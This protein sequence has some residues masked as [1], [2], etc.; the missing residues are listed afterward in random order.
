MEKFNVEKHWDDF[1]EGKLVVNCPTEELANEFLR[2]CHNQNKQW[3]IESLLCHNNWNTYEEQTCYCS[4]N[5]TM[6]Y[7]SIKYW[8]RNNFKI[9]E[10]QGFDIQNKTIA[11]IGDTIVLS[12]GLKMKLVMEKDR[13]DY[14]RTIDV[15]SGKVCTTDI[16]LETLNG[17]VVGASTWGSGCDEYDIVE[18]IK[19]VK[20]TG[21]IE[22]VKNKVSIP[23][24]TTKEIIEVIYHRKETI[25][26]IKTNGKYY[27]GVSRCHNEDT[28]DK[29]QGFIVAYQRAREN[30]LS[31]LS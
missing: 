12:N 23:T 9:I 31:K 5:P 26:L 24:T 13:E 30:Q 10:F 1:N 11:E 18:I 20:D 3:S 7:S 29:E 22:N 15:N 2:Y 27:K 4:R 17:F 6:E 16:D 14:C 21:K 19:N 25:V 28:Y 8:E